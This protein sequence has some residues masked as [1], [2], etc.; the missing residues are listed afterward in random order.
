MIA[1]VAVIENRQRNQNEYSDTDEYQLSL[2]EKERIV[3]PHRGADLTRAEKNNQ[4][5]RHESRDNQ[6]QYI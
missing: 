2:H 5:Q 3:I 4:A 6:A 1:P